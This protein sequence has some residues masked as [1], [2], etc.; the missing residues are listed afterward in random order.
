[1]AARIIAISSGKGG[2]G[3]TT[4]TAN[5]GL[6]IAKL[7][8]KVIMVD[9][10]LD[11]ANLELVLG[12]EGRPITL[13][14]VLAGEAQ[15]TDSIY[16]INGGKFVP[17]GISPS[18]FKR[19]DP[20]KFAKLIGEIGSM[21]D[22]VLLD[23]PAGIGKDTIACLSACHEV[24]LIM[25]PEPMSATDA[26]KTK[27]VTEKMGASLIGIIL[28]MVK[29]TKNELKD[30]EITSLLNAPILGRVKN[31]DEVR[32]SVLAGK[33]LVVHNPQNVSA[34]E[35]SRIAGE[36]VGVAY[37]PQAPKKSWFNFL[38]FWRRK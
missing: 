33:P 8:K 10:D 16:E 23:C 14:D 37:K 13:Q 19:V 5:I 17:A 31:D 21:A 30:K 11:M 4:M 25:T 34:Q 29:G 38:L 3:K 18:Q 9:A 27:L 12:M 36:L 28:N 1:M 32:D 24:I 6:A 35:I 22:I 15:T 7:G 2:V 20:E 26:Y